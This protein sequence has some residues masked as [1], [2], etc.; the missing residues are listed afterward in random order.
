MFSD[1]Q[2]KDLEECQEKVIILDYLIT[3]RQ[4]SGLLAKNDIEMFHGKSK[5]EAIVEGAP[6]KHITDDHLRA[7]TAK[8]KAIKLIWFSNSVVTTLLIF[9]YFLY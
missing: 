5:I 7:I 4:L 3:L 6:A 9:T 8:L 2:S 1:I